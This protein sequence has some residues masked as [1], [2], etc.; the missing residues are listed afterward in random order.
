MTRSTNICGEKV[1]NTEPGLKGDTV[2]NTLK[3]A[4]IS[5]GARNTGSYLSTKEMPKM[6]LGT[7]H[8]PEE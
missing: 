4:S 5:S 1:I 8:M 7:A 6:I 2:S 3:P